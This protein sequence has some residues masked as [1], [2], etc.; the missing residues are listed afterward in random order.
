MPALPE[1]YRQIR[2]FL[3]ECLGKNVS[4]ELYDLAENSGELPEHAQLLLDA[5]KFT[6]DSHLTYTDA[7]G[8]VHSALYIKDDYGSLLG[9]LC[10]SRDFSDLHSLNDAMRA[11]FSDAGFE[12]SDSNAAPAVDVGEYVRSNIEKLVPGGLGQARAM[13]LPEKQKLLS[14]LNEK[15]VFNIKKAVEHTIRLLDMS[16]ATVYRY[17]K[18]TENQD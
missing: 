15:G 9:M 13:S 10:V 4:A 8:V 14:A 7:L 16:Q 6:D 18:K 2:A 3:T 11:M 12:T 17:M 1:S 5:A